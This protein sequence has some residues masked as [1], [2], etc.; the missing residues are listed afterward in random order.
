MNDLWKS[1]WDAVHLFG[2]WLTISCVCH[3]DILQHLLLNSH[4]AMILHK[5]H[6]TYGKD[7][8][9]LLSLS[10]ITYGLTSFHQTQTNQ[11]KTNLKCRTQYEFSVFDFKDYWF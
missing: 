5:Q 9:T 7:I 4:F 1:C 10:K 3:Q 6:V 8:T 11:H 2:Q